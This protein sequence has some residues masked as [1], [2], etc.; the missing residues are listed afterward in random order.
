MGV[1][2]GR[3]PIYRIPFMLF[4]DIIDPSDEERTFRTIDNQIFG[5]IRAHSGGNG[6]IRIGDTQL[7]AD[8]GDGTFT[9]TLDESTTEPAFEG[10]VNQIYVAS[11]NAIQWKGLTNLCLDSCD[12]S[13]RWH[14]GDVGRCQRTGCLYV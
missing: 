1:Y 7:I 11:N 3:T 6:V 8:A 5:A 13:G 10:F 9:V 12:G 14:P 2:G 4:G